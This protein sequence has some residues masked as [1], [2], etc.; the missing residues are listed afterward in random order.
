MGA[1]DVF[2]VGFGTNRKWTSKMIREATGSW[3][4]HVW[5]EYSSFRLGGM[6][7]IHAQSEG[8]IRDDVFDVWDKYP[9]FKRYEVMMKSNEIHNGIKYAI[10][11]IGTPYDYGVII[12][13]LKL[14]WW[15]ETMRYTTPHR[16]PREL[17]CSE[18]VTLVLDYINIPNI[19]KLDPELTY[20][21]K[22][23]KFVRDSSVFR[24]V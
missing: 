23:W 16:N 15:R 7:A 17:H 3:C 2:V 22:L 21:G 20:P 5:I 6:H 10:N 8:V 19:N 12:N 24:E 11:M 13:G 14:W 1:A 9:K 18:F 4:S